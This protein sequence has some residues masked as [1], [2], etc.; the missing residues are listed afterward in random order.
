MRSGALESSQDGADEQEAN[1]PLSLAGV[2]VLIVDDDADSLEA[3]KRMLVSREA[4]VETAGS[5]EDALKLLETFHPD[6]LLS[7]IGMPGRDGFELIR[8][9]RKSGRWLPA[10]ALTALARP[11][12]RVKALEAGF[13]THVSKPV[14]RA[15]L[16]AVVRSLALLRNPASVP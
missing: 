8:T 16:V 10:A 3:V 1:T 11:V 13:Q 7:D 6:V 12:D 9:V 14:I 4:Q 2:R 5:V 15:E